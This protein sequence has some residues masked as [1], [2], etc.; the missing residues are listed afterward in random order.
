MPEIAYTVRGFLTV[1]RSPLRVPLNGSLTLEPDLGSG[2]FTGSLTLA[3]STASRNV[4]G[5]SLFSSTVQIMAESAVSGRVSED[6][7]VLATVTVGAVIEAVRVLGWTVI[8]SSSCRTAAH[9]TVPLRSGPGF[10]L[11]RG[12]RLTGSYDRP[13]FTGCG[14]ATSLVNMLVAGPGNTVVIDLVPAP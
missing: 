9:A 2:R 14:W 1:R 5:L 12:G 11:D 6:I 8:G 10:R 3:P 13:P 7:G 4:L